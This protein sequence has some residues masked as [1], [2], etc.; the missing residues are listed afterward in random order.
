[1]HELNLTNE[2]KSDK[3]YKITLQ[4][5]AIVIKSYKT[6]LIRKFRAYILNDV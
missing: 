2:S 3:D 5:F 4:T 6:S 1:M